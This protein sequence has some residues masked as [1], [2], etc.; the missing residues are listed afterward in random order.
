MGRLEAG[1]V[2]GLIVCYLTNNLST[3]IIFFFVVVT[4][5]SLIVIEIR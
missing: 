2:V 1:N 3:L 4:R 5:L